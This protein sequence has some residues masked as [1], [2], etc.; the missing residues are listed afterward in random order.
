MAEVP[1][2]ISTLPGGFPSGTIAANRQLQ[3]LLQAR[4]AKA[5]PQPIFHFLCECKATAG[6][7][8]TLGI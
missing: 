4:V 6:T 3:V 7:S 8:I 5:N 1:V 2:I